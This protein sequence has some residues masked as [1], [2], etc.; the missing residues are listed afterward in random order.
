MS[1]NSKLCLKSLLLAIAFGICSQAALG[2]VQRFKYTIDVPVDQYWT[3]SESPCLTE[4]IHVV[5]SYKEY[6][7]SLVN[8]SSG[9]HWTLHQTTD[10]LTAVGLTTGDTY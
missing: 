8:P 10:N 9:I 6:F 7:N 3:P 5:G 4:T 2:Q 1:R